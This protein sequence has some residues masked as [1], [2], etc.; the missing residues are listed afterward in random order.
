M[1]TFINTG[2][3]PLY[4]ADVV[5][6][7]GC[8]VAKWDKEPVATGKLGAITIRLDSRGRRGQSG[9]HIAVLANTDPTAHTLR[10]EGEVY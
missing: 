5:V 1:I 2:P 6:S 8:T 10:S 7:C 4:I 9:K 3:A